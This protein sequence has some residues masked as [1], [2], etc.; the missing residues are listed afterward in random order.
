MAE[1]MGQIIRRLRKELNLT[2]EELAE[3]L[4]ISAP[5][6]SKWENDTA[7][8]DISQV[9]PLTNLFGVPTDVLFG[10]NNNDHEEEI[11]K[12]LAE[13]F[14]M[15]ENCKGDDKV[16][17]AITILDKYRDLMRLYPNN[18]MIL[19]NAS[20]FA[21]MV[22]S[23][24]E[25][26]EVLGQDRIDTLIQEIVRWSGMVIKYSSAID[27]IL[28]AKSRLIDLDIRRKNWDGACKT[29]DSFPAYISNIKSI[30]MA[31]IKRL[32]GETSD[33]RD[34]RRRSI[35][36]LTKHLAD[37]MFML[38]DLYRR[39]EQYEDAVYCYS[40]MREVLNSMFREEEYRLTFIF[41]EKPLY[42]YPAFCL[43]KLCRD[44][45]AVALL[46]EGVAFI[47]AQEKYSG[48]TIQ[49]ENALLR[50]VTISY[51]F[52]GC[53]KYTLQERIINLVCCDELKPLS[54]NPRYQKLVE[55]INK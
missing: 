52:G 4:N 30:K 18:P 32:M 37:Q 28:A 42:H 8:P 25:M 41:P 51:C 27:H 35:M 19:N 38:G 33:E 6:V 44:D 12:Q 21:S 2:Q 11:K 1:T 54:E 46:E 10:V 24:N 45:E 9:V 26:R 23:D 40:V 5:A 43:M 31:E 22:I 29:A 17:I 39:Q 20:A 3:Q 48:K 50:D 34:L 15:G 36:D 49:L 16:E 47:K 7:M 14:H 53:P 55:R 13:L